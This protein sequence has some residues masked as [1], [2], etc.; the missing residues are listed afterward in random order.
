MIPAPLPENEAER[1]EALL[2]YG[3]LDTPSE[4]PFDDLALLAARVC[5]APIAFVNFVDAERLWAK[6]ALGMDFTECP[7]ELS[8]CSHTI[9]EGQPLVI[10][11][12]AMDP[13][14]AD[15]PTVAGEPGVRF[16]A[17]A[18]LVTASGHALGSLCAIDTVPRELSSAQRDGLAALARQVVAQ[19]ELR[20]LAEQ[21]ERQA[22]TDPLTAL[23]NRR[24][25]FAD[26]ERIVAAGATESHALLLF[27]LD[28]FKLYNDTF[29]HPAG[30]ALLSRLARQLDEVIAETGHAYRIGGDE[31]CALVDAGHCSDDL[32]K[33]ACAALSERGESFS[34]GSSYGRVL[35][36]DEAPNAEL[37]LQLADQRMFEHKQTRS[38]IAKRQTHDVLVRILDER[39]PELL[40]HVRGVAEM[41][42]DVAVRLGLSGEQL[43]EIVRAAELHDIGKV[44]IPDAILHKPGALTV[45]EWVFMRSHTV[46]GER[47]LSA[48]PALRPVASLVR[49]THE[50]WDGRG[51]PDGLAGEAIPL[52]ARII[53]VCDSLSAM[54]SPRSF[55]EA[56]SLEDAFEELRRCSGAQFD[57][58]VVDVLVGEVLTGSAVLEVA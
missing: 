25:L 49:S 34:V 53:F 10:E 1:L 43:D 23:G 56:L 20:L 16:Y 45:Q 32:V 55:R 52:G 13:R 35:I 50:R 9:L 39:E 18:P 42:R 7:R 40:A 54:T 22:L 17:G 14:F 12:L 30:D 41:A 5:E 36:P 37:A 4:A 51:Y 46:L 33:S 28:G 3:I 31:F 2:S 48:A 47:I 38:T 57:A 44:A 21:S 24:R 26:L 29:G 6:A 58:V 8:V 15:N 11:D 27:D 19:L